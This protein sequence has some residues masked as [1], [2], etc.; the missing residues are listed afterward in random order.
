MDNSR[1][2]LRSELN[3]AA[4]IDF[5]GSQPPLQVMAL[6]ISQTGAKLGIRTGVTLP[7]RFIVRFTANGDI[8]MVCEPVWAKDGAVGV[9]FVARAG[10][11]AAKRAQAA[12]AAANPP[13]RPLT[14]NSADR[15]RSRA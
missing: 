10:K 8:A 5:G 2:A 4:W 9:R 11:D 1:P 12:Q 6:N 15:R 14:K 7:P 3:R 13:A